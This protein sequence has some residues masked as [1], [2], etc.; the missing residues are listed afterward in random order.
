MGHAQRN[1]RL[2]VVSALIGCSGFVQAQM[3]EV[4]LPAT[5]GKVTSQ[6][7]KKLK[8]A[9]AQARWADCVKLAPQVYES[10][11]LVRG[12]ILRTWLKCA[13]ANDQEGK[14]A[15]TVFPALRASEAFRKSTLA[16]LW[17]EDLRQISNQAR[18]W[19]LEQFM[20]GQLKLA[21]E[22]LPVLM[23]DIGNKET[24]LLARAWALTGD[25]AQIR[26]DLISAE[27]AYRQSVR[28][29]NV[30]AVD[31]KW[32][33]VKL[34]LNR[35]ETVKLPPVN[36]EVLPEN[37][38]RF[39]ARMK[40]SKEKNDPLLQLEDA[41][42]YLQELPNGLR[43][44]SVAQNVL[45]LHQSIFNKAAEAG[46]SGDRWRLILERAHSLLAGGDPERVIEWAQIL[47]KRGDYLGSLRLGEAVT[48]RFEKTAVGDQ[49]LWVVARS[50]QLTGNYK[51]ADHF[52]ALFFDRHGGSELA[53]DA[54]FQWALTL[55][56][57]Q[58]FASAIPRWER[59][60]RLATSDKA[61]EKYELSIRY[62]LVRS[63]QAVGNQ[64]RAAQ[65]A[66]VIIQKFPASYYGI[67]LQ[68]EAQNRE[69]G[70]P[71]TDER[72]KS[73]KGSLR[74]S[75]KQKQT[76]DRL[77]VLRIH[78]WTSEAL[79]E[80]EDLPLPED[81]ILKA[82]WAQELARASVFPKVIRLVNELGDAAPEL[83]GL[84]V[85]QLGFPLV[86]DN[87][88]QTEAKKRGLDP[89]LVRALIRQESAFNPRAV[90]RS[91]A[92]GLMQLIPPTAKEVAENLKIKNLDLPEDAF[93]P[94]TNVQMGT[95]YL[96]RMI[97]SFSG[98]VP[99]GLAAYNAGP[100]R[101]ELFLAGRPDLREALKKASSEPSSEMWVDE[102]PWAETSFYVK[103]ILRNALLYRTLEQKKITVKEVIWSDFVTSATDVSGSTVDPK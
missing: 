32:K 42:S 92:M 75:Q 4:T 94:G 80:A 41:L 21:D 10:Q 14:K 85:L 2:A 17:S 81:P 51:K 26:H 29:N 84:D 11:V 9:E 73:L 1:W 68:S 83:R 40:T 6:N 78:G 89:V 22:H 31:E 62:W 13:F 98:S 18:L 101:M 93:R 52:Y 71:Y 19:V 59:L 53:R 30:A 100:K 64:T 37:E 27:T 91:N 36:E 45:D 54:E 35:T 23:N 44:R 61:A 77:Q 48:D 8:E 60:A 79:L 7:L 24:D 76:W 55:M 95:S 102:L 12:W 38:A 3:I 46:A 16:G 88:I 25:L 20:R 47:Y 39:V 33:A 43:S 56:R 66:A 87:E 57:N 103:A 82:L 72:L 65:E 58:D 67:R 49:L 50:A 70:W 5:L 28:L 90:S 74:L 86:H 99:L 34:A 97:R 96:A 63:L 69:Y 15:L